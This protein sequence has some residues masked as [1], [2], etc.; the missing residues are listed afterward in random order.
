MKPTFLH[1]ALL[2]IDDNNTNIILLKAMLEDEG[3]THIYSANSAIE[4]YSILES[5]AIDA[6]LM[7]VMMPE[8]DGIE[9]TAAIKANKNYAKLPIIIV[10]ASTD[11]ETLLKSFE[12]GASDFIRKPVNQIEL[13]IRLKAIL[14]DATNDIITLQQSRYEA[15]EEII[16]MLAHQW[17][18]PLGAIGAVISNLQLQIELEELDTQSCKASLNDISRY[19]SRLSSLIE[20]FRTIFKS[21]ATVTTFNVN[22]AIEKTIQVLHPSFDD[23]H[24]SL[25]TNLQTLPLISSKESHLIQTLIYILTNSKEAFQVNGIIL[26]EIHITSK[27]KDDAII[28]RIHDN[29]GGIASSIYHHIFE[30]YFTTKMEKNGKGLGLFMS[31]NL[32]ENEMHGY[33]SA[34]SHAGSSTFTIKLPLVE[35]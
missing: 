12:A 10:T 21:D 6:I 30:P 11:N 25:S 26:R 4:A 17:R 9:A 34:T 18:Q 22:D 13:M 35:L 20:E 19:S 2:I 33:L 32:I 23:L 24:I 3:F 28:I 5:T 29:A 31:K 15:M 1:N 8:I 16:A 14:K 27:V 7:D